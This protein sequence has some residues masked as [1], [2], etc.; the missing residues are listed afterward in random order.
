MLF[1]FPSLPSPEVLSYFSPAE[2]LSSRRSQLSQ[3][4]PHHVQDQTSLPQ[5]GAKHSFTRISGEKFHAWL[6]T[7]RS[8]WEVI[9]LIFCVRRRIV[10]LFRSVR[11]VNNSLWSVIVLSGFLLTFCL[12]FMVWKVSRTAKSGLRKSNPNIANIVDLTTD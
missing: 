8:P 3:S 7:H 12:T 9:R 11:L 4:R 1:Y 10:E 6:K 2:M 5:L